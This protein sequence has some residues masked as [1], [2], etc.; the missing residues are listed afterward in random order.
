MSNTPGLTSND[1]GRRP[2]KRWAPSRGT[3]LT[4]VLLDA[5]YTFNFV[6]FGEVLEAVAVVCT[7]WHTSGPSEDRRSRTL[8]RARFRTLHS[9]PGW[10]PR[11]S[12][13][14][15]WRQREENSESK[16]ADLVSAHEQERWD[17]F[18]CC[19]NQFLNIGLPHDKSFNSWVPDRPM[20]GCQNVSG[21]AQFSTSDSEFEQR[22]IDVEGDE[23]VLP[24]VC[25]GS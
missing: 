12:T 23:N 11:P 7:W 4:Q 22:G 15:E 2:K 14:L 10:M 6:L 17:I 9:M 1:N 8:H 25:P 13:Q 18:C 16:Q 20:W 19:A 5:R 3:V 24:T 21:F